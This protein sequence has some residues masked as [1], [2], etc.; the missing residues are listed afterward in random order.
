M[1]LTEVKPN[2]SKYRTCREQ[3]RKVHNMGNDTVIGYYF[4]CDLNNDSLLKS[5]ETEPMNRMNINVKANFT[6]EVGLEAVFIGR[7]FNQ[8]LGTKIVMTDCGQIE[9]K[10]IGVDV[11]EEMSHLYI[12]CNDSFV[13]IT[14][15]NIKLRSMNGNPK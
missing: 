11:Q 12:S 10:N 13:D 7:T 9:T 3:F 15:Q 1:N 8:T 4:Y 2:V 14:G 5:E 6:E